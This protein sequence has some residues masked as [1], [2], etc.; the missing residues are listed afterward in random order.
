MLEIHI[1]VVDRGDAIGGGHETRH[2]GIHAVPCGHILRADAGGALAGTSRLTDF[3]TR[4]QQDAHFGIRG[5]DRGDVTAF[6]HDTQTTGEG[7]HGR[8]TRDVRTLG[9][10]EHVTHRDDVRHLRDMAGNLGGTD[11]L[12]DVLAIR[13]HAGIVGINADVE[14]VAGEELPHRFGDHTL[15]DLLGIQIDAL[16]QTPPCACTVHG[17]GVEIRE[18]EILGQGLGRGGFS[19]AGGA[20]DGDANHSPTSLDSERTSVWLST[21]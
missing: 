12:G 11:R 15:I 6:G 1:G 5:D 16:L 14:V 17:A 18:S 20:V 4:G 21:R 3:L 13:A 9:G 2:L 19:H 7:I 8:L 10:D